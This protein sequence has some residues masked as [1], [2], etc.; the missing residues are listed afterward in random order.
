MM[1]PNER[2]LT[3]ISGQELERR[4]S[5]VRR[6]MHDRGIDAL[7][8]QSANDWLGGYVKWFT[9][10]PATN[11][12]PR[13]VIFH[14]GASMTVVEMGPFGA[15]R[16]LGGG[17]ALHRGVGDLLTAPSF[18]SVEYTHGY[19]A[20]L[21]VD[22]LWNHGARAIGFVGKGALPHALVMIEWG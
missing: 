12:Y 3:R 13:T 11:G 8:M 10:L 18:L 14:A 9:D 15:R 17:D 4:W 20:D 2:I 22:A 1:E 7:V 16:T 5:A 19:D 21:A 6:Q